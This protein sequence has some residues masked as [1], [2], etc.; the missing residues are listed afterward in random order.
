MLYF[1]TLLITSKSLQIR[2]GLKYLGLEEISNGRVG[3]ITSTLVRDSTISAT[4]DEAQADEKI[5]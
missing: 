5:R 4:I 1:I 3:E 2:G